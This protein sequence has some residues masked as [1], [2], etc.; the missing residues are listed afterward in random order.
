M[1]KK[2]TIGAD[3][4]GT[5]MDAIL[6]DGEKMLAS[7]RL[8]TPQNNLKEFVD[9]FVTL[10]NPLL[11]KAKKEKLKISNL[12]IGVAGTLNLKKETILI[13]P[14]IP[15]LNKVKLAK[16]IEKKIGIKTIMENDTRCFTIAE[17]IKGAGKNFKEVYGVIL[18]TGI[19]G[20]WY[21]H[22]EI[23]RGVHGGAGEPGGIM[24]DFSSQIRF[25]DAYHQMMQFSPKKFSEEAKL[26][27]PLGQ[28][29]YEEFGK[30]LGMVLA[31]ITN[32]I[33]PEIFIIGGGTSSSHKLFLAATKKS[34]AE[35]VQSSDSRKTKIVISK[36][37]KHAGS[38]GAALLTK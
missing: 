27:D 10:I 3:I 9:I 29:T 17:A 38:I 11:E 14:N 12:G 23:F 32:I 36:L 6:W 34:F 33:N 24:I 2:Y 1:Q 15:L 35:Y 30:L 21:H 13:A 37:G 22:G 26:N 25:E 4:G 5:K 31:G 20:A 18:G 19:G 7:N 8:P 16:I 28:K